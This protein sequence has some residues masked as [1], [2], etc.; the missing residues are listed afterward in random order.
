MRSLVFIIYFA[1]IIFDGLKAQ[2]PEECLS[3]S[4]LWISTNGVSWASK[5]PNQPSTT[6]CSDSCG[7]LGIICSNGTSGSITKM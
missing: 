7:W 4:D 1:I 6:N 3:L 5:W 2:S